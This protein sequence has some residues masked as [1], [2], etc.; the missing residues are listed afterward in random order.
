MRW[1][2]QPLYRFGVEEEDAGPGGDHDQEGD[3]DGQ[4]HLHRFLSIGQ[5]GCSLWHK[6]KCICV[7]IGTQDKHK[8]SQYGSNKLLVEFNIYRKQAVRHMICKNTHKYF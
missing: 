8:E 3:Q 1:Q 5:L 2:H 7:S 4:H 6:L